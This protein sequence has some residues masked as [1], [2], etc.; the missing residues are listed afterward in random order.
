MVS[1]EQGI[2]MW[3]LRFPH[4]R[5][6][7]S[8]TVGDLGAIE[9]ASAATGI[10][11]SALFTCYLRGDWAVLS[12]ERRQRLRAWYAKFQLHIKARAVFE[13]ILSTPDENASPTDMLA[14]LFTHAGDTSSPPP[15][16]GGESDHINKEV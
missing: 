1:E 6:P 15:S 13:D 14:W 16:A 4:L 9:I 12:A 5:R 10:P 8:L 11:A 7:S 2:D 3:K